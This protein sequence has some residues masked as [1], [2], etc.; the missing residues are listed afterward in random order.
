MSK[1]FGLG[2]KASEYVRQRMSQATREADEQIDRQGTSQY[3]QQRKSLFNTLGD[4]I[5]GRKKGDSAAPSPPGGMPTSPGAPPVVR[6][7]GNYPQMPGAPPVPSKPLWTSQPPQPPIRPTTADPMGIRPGPEPP[8]EGFDDIQLLGRD[9]S[10][11]RQDWEVVQQQMRLTPGSSNVYGYYFEFESRTTGILYVTFLGTI[12]G[13]GR[14][15]AGPTYAY[16]TVPAAVYHRFQ[17]ECESSAGSAVWD[18]LRI[19]GTIWGHQFTYRLIQPG[20]DYVPRKATQKGFR[21][22]NVPAIGTGRRSYQRSTLPER[23]FPLKAKPD[24]GEPNRGE[25]DRG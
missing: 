21:T 12:P 24:R 10:Y 19:R 6:P 4:F 23:L 2:R 7:P 13:G 9:A 17:R 18:N 14:G 1:L 8:D 22:R 15:G 5:F 25:P 20:G 11:D 16:Y 3:V